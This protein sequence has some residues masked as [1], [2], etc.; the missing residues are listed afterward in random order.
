VSDRRFGVD[1]LDYAPPLD[2]RSEEEEIETNRFAARV[3]TDV[4]G[5]VDWSSKAPPYWLAPAVCA[6]LFLLDERGFANRGGE[7]HRP[8]DSLSED[9]AN[10]MNIE[11]KTADAKGANKGE[12]AN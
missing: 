12:G 1:G 2:R 3:A 9:G 4:I 7:G 8:Q 5:V 10:R 11:D 6:Q